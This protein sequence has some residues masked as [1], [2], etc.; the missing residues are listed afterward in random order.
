M[1]IKDVYGKRWW[2]GGKGRGEM[3]YSLAWGETEGKYRMGRGEM[4]MW[5]GIEVVEGRVARGG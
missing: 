4:E 5:K 2:R 3:E 1:W